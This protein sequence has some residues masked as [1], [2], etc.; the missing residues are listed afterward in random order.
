MKK[1]MIEREHYITT[2]FCPACHYKYVYDYDDKKIIDGHK[3]FIDIDL[4]ATYT[5]DDYYRNTEKLDVVMCPKC[6]C[7]RARNI[8]Q[9]CE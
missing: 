4:T 1:E 8:S 9:E 3:P 7:L 6:G 2:E 5:A